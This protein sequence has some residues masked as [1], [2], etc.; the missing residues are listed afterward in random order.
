M[1]I[2][3]ITLQ[4]KNI[5]RANL[6]VDG[7]FY[8]G[9]SRVAI[10]NHKL[11]V[12]KEIDQAE[13]DKVI[14]DS[15]KDKAFDYALTYISK[16]TP[17]EK[18]LKDKLYEKGYGKLI[19]EYTVDKCKKYGYIND[20][21]YARSYIAFNSS[22]KGKIRIKNELKAK[23]IADS[24]IDEQLSKMQPNDSCSQLA[25]K[26]SDGMD[27]NDPKN[28]AKLIRFLQYRGYEWEDISQALATLKIVDDDFS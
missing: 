11:E 13:L 26:K 15:D 20:A 23:G 5:D 27:V 10:Y 4:S 22:V 19:V 16:Y 3:D 2:T 6:F 12:G 18:G 1:R 25:K 24:I 14:F 28:R 8:S 7:K 17:T 9:V 21:E